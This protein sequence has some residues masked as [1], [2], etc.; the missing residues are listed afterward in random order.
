MLNSIKKAKKL[1]SRVKKEVDDKV[2]PIALLFIVFFSFN[3]P[4]HT[5]ASQNAINSQEM[6]ISSNNIAPIEEYTIVPTQPVEEKPV[7]AVKPIKTMHVYITAYNSLENQTDKTP[8][9]TANGYNVCESGVEDTVA[10]NFLPLGTRIMI[11][12]Y[13]KDRVF[14]VRDRTNVKYGDRVDV[15][16]REY[17]DAKQFGKRYLRI[18]VLAE[19][20]NKQIVAN[21]K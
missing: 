19:K 10:A 7:E 17:K 11:P 20:E 18:E 6:S 16:M 5:I 12:D 14:V 4:Q 8:C 9:I 21:I 2:G 15:W 1:A 13:F 3:F